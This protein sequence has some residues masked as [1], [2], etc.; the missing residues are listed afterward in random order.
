MSHRARKKA[1]RSKEFEELAARL[2]A[3]L[4]PEGAR[5]KSPDRL[6]D[7]FTGQ[8]REVDASI[9]Y[10]IGSSNILITIE[11]R[12]RVRTQDVT[13]IEQLATKRLHI[14]ADRTLAVSSSPFT[15]AALVAAKTHGISTRLISEVTDEDIRAQVNTLEVTVHSTSLAIRQLQLHYV[16]HIDPSPGLAPEAAAAWATN[17]WDAKLFRVE[18][19]PDQASLD[20]LIK[21]AAKPTQRSDLVVLQTAPQPG[22]SQA[23]GTD[24]LLPHLADVLSDG[25]TVEKNFGLTFENEKVLVLTNVG[26]KQLRAVEITLEVTRSGQ[27]VPPARIG[28]YATESTLITNFAEHKFEW[29][30]GETWSVLSY[31]TS[32]RG[33]REA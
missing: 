12:D 32:A 31:P 5:V 24:L 27:K 29:K 7:Q 28:S 6:R 17:G 1:S 2:E 22:T 21:L 30:P 26:W 25:S 15:E 16:E 14:R 19:S 11:C 20:D 3:A 9:R 33:K 23:K 8:S 10:S 18:G 13:W 4:A